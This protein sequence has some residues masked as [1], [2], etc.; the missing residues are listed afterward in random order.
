MQ[1]TIKE[2]E[3]RRDQ[4]IKEIRTLKHQLHKEQTKA[5]QTAAADTQQ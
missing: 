4:A 3:K 5:V 1:A 2:L